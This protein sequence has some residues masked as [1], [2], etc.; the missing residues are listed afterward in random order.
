MFEVEGA[1]DCKLK[2]IGF[3]VCFVGTLTDG[4]GGCLVGMVTAGSGGCDNGDDDGTANVDSE[5]GLAACDEEEEDMRGDE[6]AA[7]AAAG[8]ATAPMFNLK[9]WKL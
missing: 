9:P 4:S 3:A 7:A 2:A 5:N 8:G 1:A 6:V